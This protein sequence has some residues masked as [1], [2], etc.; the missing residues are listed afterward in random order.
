VDEEEFNTAAE[1][2]QAMLLFSIRAQNQTGK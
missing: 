1:V 2:F